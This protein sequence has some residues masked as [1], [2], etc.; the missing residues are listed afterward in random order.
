MASCSTLLQARLPLLLFLGSVFLAMA[1]V[2]VGLAFWENQNPKNHLCVK[3][4]ELE[5]GAAYR[6]FA[7]RSRCRMINEIESGR[8]PQEQE[9]G[10]RERERGRDPQERGQGQR[11]KARE[12]E[13]REREEERRQREERRRQEQEEEQR[14]REE[15]RREREDERRRRRQGD[16]DDDEEGREQEEEG[17]QG[18]RERRE[19]EEERRRRDERRRQ[20]REEE[21]RQREE[22][23]RE[24]E[25]ERR[26]RR[27]GDDDDDDD[28][29]E[30]GRDQEEEGRQGQRER[31]R[32]ER[33]EE[34]RRRD[35]R[36][37]QE[38]E[39]EQR[40]RGEQ[41]RE[42][43][44][45]RRSRRKGDDNDDE[46]SREQ[47]ERRQGQREKDRRE[48]EEERRRRDERRR[49]EREEEQRQREQ[50][51]RE[52]EDERRRRREGDEEG[53]ESHRREQEEEEQE[54]EEELERRG[55]QNQNPYHFRSGSFQTRF[56]NQHGS[57]RILPRFDKKSNHL[58][59]LRNYRYVEYAL[60]PNSLF[61]P[62][63]RDAEALLIAVEGKAITTIVNQT[64]RE[65]HHVEQG[66]VL[67]I[68][69]GSLV[70][71][72]N[73]ENRRFRAASLILPTNI[74]GQ[75]ENLYPSGNQNPQS[76]YKAFSKKTLEATFDREYNEI[77]RVLLRQQEQSSEEGVMV[78]LS[79]EQARELRKQAESSS[80]SPRRR[81]HSSSSSS[82]I[83]NLRNLQPRYSNDNGKLWEARPEE[84][85]LL[86]D[87]EISVVWLELKRG[88]LFLPH[89][90]TK[91]IVVGQIIDGTSR[92]EIASPYLANN[93]RSEEQE[94]DQEREREQEQE[95]QQQDEERREGQIQRVSSKL[96]QGDVFL[97][98]A[99]HP[100]ALRASK[101]NDLRMVAF[102]L[103]AENNQRNF[104]GGER[105]NVVNQ[106]PKTVK[107]LAFPGSGEEVEKLLGNQK[108][109]YF[110]NAQRR[111]QRS[112]EDEEEE[113]DK[114]ER[115]LLSSI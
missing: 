68:P 71:T 76:Y 74:P 42:R 111:Q 97:A 29:D 84:I 88:S 46:E 9:Q 65:T 104:L 37:R 114:E 99:G 3:S 83:L 62:H 82:C 20:E 32:R 95:Q 21:Q 35:E 112:D 87:L 47:E 92:L 41:R 16:D 102:L 79:S 90:N 75:Y 67:R 6:K 48:R 59:G 105:D 43:E 26:R 55:S 57:I 89:Y 69:P 100:L 17:R 103:N 107:G 54:Q 18:Q 5:N 56:Q 31:D 93:Q 39:E 115:A 109:S 12:Q 2:S 58:R 64:N 51:R 38:R 106:M 33:E 91:A 96:H 101:K 10:Q 30:E 80:S 45:E 61:I 63:H 40:Q 19:R 50:Q 70:Y 22:Q 44:D 81:R 86:Q 113:G 110:V 4:C 8:D 23:R 13:R 34:R 60:R 1:S 7:C 66:D 25:D 108:K 15:Q 77:Q 85:N 14:Q 27:Q 53:P 49:Q 52:R 94:Q 72:A 24:R 78:Q 36:R 98:L 28:D 11:E 73:I